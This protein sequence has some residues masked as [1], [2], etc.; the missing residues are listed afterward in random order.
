MSCQTCGHPAEE[1]NGVPVPQG[2][3]FGCAERLR[4]HARNLVAPDFAGSLCL[5]DGCTNPRAVSKGP[6]PAKYCDEHKTVR[7][8]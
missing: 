7:S 6:R 1:V 4:E 3:N 2:H 5:K 8:K